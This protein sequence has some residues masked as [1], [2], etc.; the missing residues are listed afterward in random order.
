MVRHSYPGSKMKFIDWAQKFY[1]LKQ[2]VE[3][4]FIP[5]LNSLTSLRM[6][7]TLIGCLLLTAIVVCRLSGS[8]MKHQHFMHFISRSDYKEKGNKI[9]RI[10]PEFSPKVVIINHFHPR[11]MAKRH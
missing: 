5:T 6:G 1:H 8:T 7:K 3:M 11:H 10:T 4:V 9:P 2:C